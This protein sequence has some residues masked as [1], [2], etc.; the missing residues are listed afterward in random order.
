MISP[1]WPNFMLSSDITIDGIN[2]LF[3]TS[4]YETFGLVLSPSSPVDLLRDSEQQ[5]TM[6][7][8]HYSSL[9]FLPAE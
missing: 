1:H 7:E 3:Q 4:F 9:R 8:I 5:K 2:E 6:E